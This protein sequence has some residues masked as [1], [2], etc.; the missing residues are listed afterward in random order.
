MSAFELVMAGLLGL[1]IVSVVVERKI[2]GE[3]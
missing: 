2:E 3:P 1:V